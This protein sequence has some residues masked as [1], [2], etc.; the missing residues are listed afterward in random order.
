MNPYHAIGSF[1]VGSLSKSLIQNLFWKTDGPVRGSIVYC[2][3][4]FGY[5][6][7]SGVYMGNGRIIHR[8]GK[9]LIEAASIRQFLAD[10]TALS[11]YV[12][13]NAQGRAV[14]NESTVQIAGAMLD[15]QT[16]YSL[17]NENCHQF[18]SHCLSGD[19]F[20]NTFTLTQLKRDAL[21]HIQASQWRVW[22]LRGRHKG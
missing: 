3:L 13:C 20:S 22:D 10:T 2:D 11:I 6:E 16:D 7:H 14:G 9:G 19:I 18:C 1:V 17:L 4:A 8:N 5:A 15:V 21:L 12:S